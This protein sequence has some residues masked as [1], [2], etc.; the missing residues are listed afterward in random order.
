MTCRHRRGDPACSKY[1]RFL[2]EEAD[3]EILRRVADGELVPVDSPDSGKYDISR[4]ERVGPHL[5]VEATY[6]NCTK[7]AYE[8]RKV[9]V[10]LNITEIDAIRWKRID[11]HFRDPT[12][13]YPLSEAPPP[14]ARFPANDAGWRDAVAYAKGKVPGDDTDNL[15]ALVDAIDRVLEEGGKRDVLPSA[16]P[17]VDA[18]YGL[19]SRSKFLREALEDAL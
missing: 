2:K 12:L 11:P 17:L 8:G 3:K 1:P 4:I 19:A 18:L 16:C 5:V 7:C 10:F 14:V 6:P 13:K 9:M 15:L